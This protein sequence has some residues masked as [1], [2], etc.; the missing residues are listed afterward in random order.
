MVRLVATG[1]I[2][3]KRERRR[4]PEMFATAL[5]KDLRMAMLDL[6][7]IANYRDIT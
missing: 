7:H 3:G 2:K 4:Q 5:T 1:I 6:L